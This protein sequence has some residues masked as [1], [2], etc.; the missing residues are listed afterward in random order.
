MLIIK[1]LDTGKSWSFVRVKSG[2]AEAY[3]KI[4]EIIGMG[5]RVGG[6]VS[7]VTYVMGPL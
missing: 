5:H 1:D 6:D 7:D 2:Y 3:A 4:Q